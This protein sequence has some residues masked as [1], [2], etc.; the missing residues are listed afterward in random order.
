[1]DV[2]LDH[3]ARDALHRKLV[4]RFKEPVSVVLFAQDLR[5]AHL[6]EYHVARFTMK[7]TNLNVGNWKDAVQLPTEYFD[8]T[9]HTIVVDVECFADDHNDIVSIDAV[10][11]VF[12]EQHQRTVEMHVTIYVAYVLA[13]DS[14]M[15][16]AFEVIKRELGEDSKLNITYG[17]ADSE[18]LASSFTIDDC[19]SKVVFPINTR[20]EGG[21]SE[22]LPDD[23]Q[24]F[25]VSAPERM[26]CLNTNA[27]YITACSSIRAALVEFRRAIIRYRTP[28]VTLSKQN[29]EFFFRRSE[30]HSDYPVR[31]CKVFMCI[32][33]V[34]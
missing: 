25:T 6:A 4:K 8:K 1:M 28:G 5:R 10:V 13:Q 15:R 11:H 12:R 2:E 3:I 9:L 24:A 22:E 17:G 30:C 14:H 34:D 27:C 7:C 32:T 20:D 18:F 23:L 16:K 26:S 19:A 31:F 33:N 29:V 21:F